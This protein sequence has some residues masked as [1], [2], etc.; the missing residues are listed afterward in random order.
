MKKILISIFLVMMVALSFGYFRTLIIKKIYPIK[1]KAQIDQYSK[2]FEVD[3]Y[4]VCSIIWVESKYNVKAVSDKGAIGLMQ[5]MP[6]TGSWIAEKIDFEQYEQDNL[7]NP[8]INIRLG[9]W[10][11]SYLDDRFGGKVTHIS[12]AYNG[13]PNR[14][15][16]WIDDDRYSTNR[17]LKNIPL[18]ETKDYVK[19]VEEAYEIYS[20][21]Y[22]FE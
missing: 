18:K 20:N 6:E 5:I 12:A 9:C 16:Q 7:S 14:V 19:R 17:E 10:Y 8:S 21:Y 15:A 13:G 4:L 2:E 22:S 3:P 1:Y 11:L